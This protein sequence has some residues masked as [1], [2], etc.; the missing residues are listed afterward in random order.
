MDNN[1]FRIIDNL[2]EDVE[3]GDCIFGIPLKSLSKDHAIKV[4]KNLTTQYDKTLKRHE[5]D[6]KILTAVYERK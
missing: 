2:P 6:I 4:I 3:D 5:S 1:P